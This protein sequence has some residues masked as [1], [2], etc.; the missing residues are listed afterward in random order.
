MDWFVGG[1]AVLVHGAHANVPL[2]LLSEDQYVAKGAVCLDGGPPGFYYK[3]ADP[4]KSSDAQAT[5]S[6][7]LYFKGGG[8]CYNEKDCA[9]RAAGQ[10]GNSSH[11]PKTLALVAL[12]MRLGH[13]RQCLQ[14]T[15]M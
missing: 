10:L 3:S 7:L 6:W 9:A 1:L 12:R 2:T 4:S 13:C 11:F 8:W 15:T 5:T 14:G